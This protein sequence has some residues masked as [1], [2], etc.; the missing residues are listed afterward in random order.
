MSN[1]QYDAMHEVEE[2]IMT[3]NSNK[4]SILTLTS[5]FTKLPLAIPFI[6]KLTK[7]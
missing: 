7:H 1:E 5:Y 6:N 2:Q 4:L 3:Q